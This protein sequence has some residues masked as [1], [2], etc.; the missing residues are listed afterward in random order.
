[1]GPRTSMRACPGGT[2]GTRAEWPPRLPPA[3]DQDAPARP[4]PVRGSCPPPDAAGSLPA[5]ASPSRGR[6]GSTSTVSLDAARPR[7][8]D[9]PG[10]ARTAAVPRSDRLACRQRLARTGSRRSR[11]RVMPTGSDAF[12]RP[13]RPRG[14]FDTD[15]VTGPDSSAPVDDA[16]DPGQPL[17]PSI[18]PAAQ[19]LLEE[20]RR[21]AVDLLARIAQAGHRDQGRTDVQARPLRQLEHSQPVGGDVLPELA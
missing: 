18:L 11:R 5:V 1:P 13:V 8:V 20:S 19:D 15:L 14:E 2:R 16:H 12:E 9:A 6:V 17:D 3:A 4:A 10:S 21:E 7:A